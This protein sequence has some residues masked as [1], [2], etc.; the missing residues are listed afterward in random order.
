MAKYVGDMTQVEMS[1]NEYRTTKIIMLEREF[2]I[3]LKADE[4]KHM[5]TLQTEAA[6][7]RFARTI[8]QKGL[9]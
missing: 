5:M 7:D 4:K 9:N 8:I 2:M 3:R 1:I 6:I